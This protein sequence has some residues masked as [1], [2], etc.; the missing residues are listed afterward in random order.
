MQRIR[1]SIGRGVLLLP[2]VSLCLGFTG[3]ALAIGL[4]LPSA[5]NAQP[6]ELRADRMVIN[7]QTGADRVL[8][9]G[10][11]GVAEGAV[12]LIDVNGK[13]R[14]G[15]E[16]GGADGSHPNLFGFHVR[17]D[18]G[19]IVGNLGTPAD[20]NGVTLSLNDQQGHQRITLLVASDGTS[21]IQMR[22]ADGNVT[23]STP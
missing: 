7:S 22:D 17:A 16:M 8:L 14:V 15:V 2:L 3:S 18:D 21:S 5:S 13:P 23:W 19:T 20:G 1:S 11:G 4:L 12:K 6:A 9:E 10:S